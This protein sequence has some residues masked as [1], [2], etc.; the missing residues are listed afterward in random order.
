MGSIS[1]DEPKG[2]KPTSRRELLKTGGA[3]AGGLTVGAVAPVLGQTSGEAPSHDQAVISSQNAYPMVPGSKELTEYGQR[4]HYVTSVRIAHPMGGRPSPDTFGKS[5]HIASPL[6]DSVG[7]ITPS[8]LHYVATTRGSFMPD[9]DPRAHT[10]MIHGL[11]DQPLTLTMDDL[12]RF[13]SVTRLHFIECAGNRHTP[14]HKTVQESHG[15]TSCSEWTGVLLSTLLKECGLKSSATWFVA[16]GAEE[17]KGASS[18]PI[19]KAMDDTLIAYGQNGEPLRPQQG[20]PVRI[21]P[22]GFEGIFHTK[23]LRRIKVVDR[24]YMNYSDFGHL[25]EDEKEAA[26]HLQIGPK[27]VIT[28]PSGGQQLPGK[29][30]YE[31]IGLAWSGGGAIKTVEV[32]VDGGKKWMPAEL[33]STPQRMAHVR[34]SLPWT[35]DGSETEILSRCTDEIGQQQPTLEQTAKFWNKPFDQNYKMPGMNNSVMPWRIAK[36]GKVT[37]GLA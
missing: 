36:D 24:Y 25:E 30:F 7:N 22:P 6:Q 32:S 2:S 17:V 28:R 1:K 29:G 14:K 15:M 18:M 37:N 34:F 3:L 4:S 10:L 31:I 20:F 35:W 21:I 16:E 27:S 11:V 23:Y 26:L 5:F 33:K 19:A 12:K 13:P 8:S 9:I